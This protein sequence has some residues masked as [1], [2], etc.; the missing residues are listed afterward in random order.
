MSLIA[1]SIMSKKLASGSDAI[2]LDVKTGDGAFMEQREDAEALGALMVKMGQASGKKTIAVITDMNQPLGLAVGNSVEVMEAIDV[3]K[4]K[5]P[6]D[7]TELA[8]TLAGLM[9]YAGKK[10]SS[11]EEGRSKAEEALR[12]GAALAKLG[13]FIQGQ[14]GDPGVI[15]DYGLFPQA[16]IRRQVI[17]TEDGYVQRLEARAIG[18]ASQH[19]GAGRASKEDT[20]DLSAGILLMKKVGDPVTKGDVLA[21]V[22]GNSEEKVDAAVGEVLKAFHVGMEIPEKESL[23]KNILLD[24]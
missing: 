17:S 23:I 2:V 9:I 5:G 24:F 18:M 6:E 22:F 21:E 16:T 13:D 11:P 12:S 19:S 8:L 3:L 14:G 10:A 20:I 15:D 4:G 7:I 1:S